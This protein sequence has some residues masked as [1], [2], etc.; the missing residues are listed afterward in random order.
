M[1]DAPRNG[2]AASL[3]ELVELKTHFFTQDGVVRA[4][5]GVNL[6]MRQGETLSVVGESGSGKTMTALSILRL[7]DPPGRIVGGRILFQGVDLLPLGEAQMCRIRGR[8]IAMVFQ[9]PMTAFDPLYRVGDQIEEALEWHL[10][11]DR[12]SRRTRS[13]QALARVGI[14]A[15]EV[16]AR[17]YPHEFSGGMIQRAMIAMALAC[18]PKL[19]IA[20]EPTTALDVTMEAQIVTLLRDLQRDTGMSLIYVT[21]NMG[22]VAR[23]AHRVAVMYAGTLVETAP[24]KTL[25]R[26][27]KHPYTLGLM[28]SV[29]RVDADPSERLPAIE[30]L[31]PDL[32]DMPDACPFAPRCAYVMDRCWAERPVLREVGDQHRIACFADL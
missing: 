4:V 17:S 5:D 1:V 6:S 32:I 27:P 22:V 13:V 11:L 2:Q 3:L 24:T 21:H 23:I 7:V 29:P 19:L 31:P 12:A 14:P 25:F 15:P 30:G 20:D 16:R 26:E 10:G 9:D 8:E 18:E 28:H